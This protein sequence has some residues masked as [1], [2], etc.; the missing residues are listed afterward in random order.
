M[1]G[2][3]PQFTGSSNTDIT[4]LYDYVVALRRELYDLLNNLDDDNMAKITAKSIATDTLVVG[5]NIKMGPG[6]T[7]AWGNVSGVPDD[8]VYTAVLASYP[9]ESELAE[10]L[11]NYTTNATLAIALAGYVTNGTL[12][13]ALAYYLTEGDFNTLIG[14]DY[15]VTGKIAANQIAAGTISAEFLSTNITQVDKNLRIGLGTDVS[16][17]ITFRDV[18]NI[19]ASNTWLTIEAQEAII[20]NTHTTFTQSAL[21]SGDVSF[22]GAV[23][24]VNAIAK[25]A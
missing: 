2:S 17:S 8:I 15:I 12:S 22:G 24:G 14:E 23:T 4:S 7:I 11:A 21:F 16:S 1:F 18:A 9:T 3:M 5:E 6:A 25:F 19:T 10:A 20:M 13:D